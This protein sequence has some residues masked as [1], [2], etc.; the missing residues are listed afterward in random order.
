MVSNFNNLH[1]ETDDNGQKINKETTDLNWTLGSDEPNRYTQNGLFNS[2]RNTFFLK[3]T[4]NIHQD[5]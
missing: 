5:I 1:S 4:W 3:R 2:S